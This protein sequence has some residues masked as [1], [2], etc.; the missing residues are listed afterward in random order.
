MMKLP[1]SKW[2]PAM[3]GLVLSVA[4]CPNPASACSVCFGDTDSPLAKGALAGVLVLGSIVYFVVLSFVGFG[5]FWF[6]RARKLAGPT[7]RVG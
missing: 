3:I 7:N 6:V 2:L 5:I 4:T 1:L